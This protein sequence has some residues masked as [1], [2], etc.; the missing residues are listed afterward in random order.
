M[1]AANAPKPPR[2]T[3]PK[4]YFVSSERDYLESTLSQFEDAPETRTVFE[5]IGELVAALSDANKVELAFAVIAERSGDAVDTLA[6][7]TCKLSYPQL[8]YIV[9]L[10]ECRQQ[11]AVRFQSLGV[12]SVLLP[13][14]SEIDLNREI[15]TALP[16]I[17]QFKRSSDLM[18]RGSARLDFLIPSDLSYVLGVNHLISLLLKEFAFPPAD[19]RINIPLACDEA[20]TNAI[21]HGNKSDPNKKVSLQIY[22]SSS[23]IKFR[24]KDQG[25]GFDVDRVENPLEGE[26]LMRSSGRG[27]YLMKSIMDNVEFKDG[28]RVLEMEKA[29]NGFGKRSNG[30]HV[31]HAD[32][33][34]PRR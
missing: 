4:V 17:P 16:N 5:S 31:N 9:I 22:I 1:V 14:F 32:R 8:N 29:N 20:I 15:A 34:R 2:A 19:T 23:R 26:N 13:P 21:V 28:G 11:N 10:E 12:Q 3:D 27:V 33:G 7:R 24:I 25:E 6:L 18:G 30:N